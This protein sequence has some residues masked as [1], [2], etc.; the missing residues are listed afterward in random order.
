M[1]DPEVLAASLATAMQQLFQLHL[2]GAQP[3][4]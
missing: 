3:P 4:Q 1:P 2:P